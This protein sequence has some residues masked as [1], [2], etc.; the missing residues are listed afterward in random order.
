M[1]HI[2]P[3]TSISKDGRD[4]DSQRIFIVQRL[5]E[6]VISKNQQ[7]KELVQKVEDLEQKIESRDDDFRV[8]LSYSQKKV[9]QTQNEL[10]SLEID[11]SMYYKELEKRNKEISSLNQKIDE[12]LEDLKEL[13]MEYEKVKK[14]NSVLRL[15]KEDME[16]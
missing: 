1:H 11:K 14:Q 5:K 3:E 8:Q 7:I 15:Q 13:E 10:G 6:C 4:Q 12:I 16:K 2:V 9:I